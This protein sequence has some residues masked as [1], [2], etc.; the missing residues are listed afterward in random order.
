MPRAQLVTELASRIVALQLPHPTR[1]AVD[2]VDA[3]GKTTLCEELVAPIEALG[4]PVVRASVD[5]FHHPAA[6]R[7]RRGSE[8][9][10]GYF[11]DA[12]DYPSLLEA[13]LHPLGPDGSRLFR[14]C[15]FDY[16]TD[17]PV[18]VP[19]ERAAADSVL[20]FDGVFLHR[21]ELQS[22]WDFSIFVHADF[23]VTVARAESRDQSLFGSAEA[24]RDRYA[25][26]YVPGQ[27]LYLSECRPDR[28]ATV[29]VD[30]NDPAHPVLVRTA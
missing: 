16:R 19:A 22:Q 7:R 11:R 15:V 8:S 17:A 1:V 18:D 23:D 27:R 6:V 14:R 13:L 24:V 26:R 2:G 21:P 29:L 25:R 12:F 28:L 3:A 9:P 20:L 5:G 30:N 4:R 10:E